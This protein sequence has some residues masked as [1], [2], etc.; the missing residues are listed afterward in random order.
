MWSG[1][2]LELFSP[3]MP[4]YEARVVEVE[5][6]GVK[7]RWLVIRSQAARE[8]AKATTERQLLKTAEEERKRFEALCREEFACEAD[9]YQG[10]ERYQESCKALEVHEVVVSEVKHYQSRG[11]PSKGSVPE[12]V[13]YRLS[14]A[15]ASPLSVFAERVERGSRFIL[16]TN[17]VNAERLKDAGVLMAY[18]GQVHAERGFR[19]LKDPMFLANTLYLKKPERIMALLMV[20]T[21]CLLVYAALEH[22]IRKTLGESGA[23]VPDQKGKSTKTPTAKWVFELFLDVHLLLITTNTLQVLTMN[24]EDELRALLHL[25]GPPYA[26]V[27]S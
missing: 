22:R 20:M 13:T 8:R 16:A 25:L 23:S 17:D 19:F 24:L 21:V 14:G 15:L 10:L 7:Q 2:S 1:S 6:A 11:R 3:L 4:G 9:A 18:K 26:E 12:R 5:Y 27:Y